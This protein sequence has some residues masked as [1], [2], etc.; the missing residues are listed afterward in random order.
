MVEV[1]VEYDYLSKEPDELTIKKGDV[2]KD[3]LKKSGGWWEGVL[4]DKRGM[5]PDNFVRVIDKDSQV[6]LRSK[7]DVTRIR[8]CRVV[9]SYKQENQDELNLSIGDVIT[10]LGEE[11]EGWWRGTLNGREGVFP[12]NFVEEIK[13]KPGSKEDLSNVDEVKS[14]LLPPKP[15]KTL[16]QVKYSYK[17]QND[18]EL[19]LK[20]DDIIT[21]ISSDGQ[22]PGWWKGELQGRVG[23]F[24]DNFVVILSDQDDKK[25]KLPEPTVLKQP[26]SPQRKSLEEKLDAEVSKVSPPIPSKKPSIPIK[27]SPSSSSSQGGLL[28]GLR[29]KIVDVV[30]GAS[31]S[32]SQPILLTKA[33]DLKVDNKVEMIQEN[34]FDQVERTS[35]LSDVRATRVK[36]PGRRPPSVIFKEAET[37]I[38]NGNIDHI[39]L[40]S[41][42]EHHA[43]FRS[44]ETSHEHL[45][46]E[47]KPKV[48]EWEKH[49][50]PWL[51]EMK[52]NQAKRTSTSPGPEQTRSKLT[53][54]ADKSVSPEVEEIKSSKVSPFDKPS[55]SSIDMSK[56]MSAI[57]N[58]SKTPPNE[59]EKNAVILRSR[60]AQLFPQIT[61]RPQ[62][63]SEPPKPK[64]SPSLHNNHNKP[65]VS[66]DKTPDSKLDVPEIP[67]KQFT[68]LLQRIE[69][70][71]TLVHQQNQSHKLAIE[72]LKG[73]LQVETDMRRLL[74]AELDK[75]S[76][77]VMQV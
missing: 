75:V 16:C 4:N 44:N 40:D 47:V 22:D 68:E 53:P 43:H 21:L 11:E 64:I 77:C 28:A 67:P 31:G 74:Q 48:R 6:T 36:A 18:D 24:P 66:E 71:E 27:K 45:E 59:L 76:Q 15:V 58:R 23:V 60:P 70:L 2:I 14:P 1:L 38:V 55:G 25:T 50:A 32:K 10:I 54:T 7:R 56:S 19:T 41:L 42:P 17:A 39:A 69:K 73:K 8:Q 61:Q 51:E 65:K 57:T 46:T 26:L 9:F 3:V 30:D 12:S 34:A 62:T 33:S 13:S 5:F 63:V 20:E 72:E 35:L 52:L 49:K 37:G 29:K